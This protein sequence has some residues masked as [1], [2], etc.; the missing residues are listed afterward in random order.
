[1]PRRTEPP[2]PF[3]GDPPATVPV[4]P[5]P[6]DHAARTV[7]VDP[8]RNVALEASAGTGKTRVLVDRYV[9]L[10]EAGVDPTNVL[11]ITFTRKAAAEMRQRIVQTLRDAASRGEI[12]PARWREL[13]DR[14]GEIAISTI[15]AFCLSLLREFP[16]EADVDPGLAMADE[17]E[18]PRLIDEALDRALG[19]CRRL[20]REDEDVAL[21]FAQL[22]EARL[23]RG[24]AALL[25]RRLV[26][27]DALR[28]YL[29]R[30]PRALDAAA[31]CQRFAERL[32]AAFDGAPG[33]LD[34]FLA[35]APAEGRRFALLTREIGDLRHRVRDSLPPE[36]ARVQALIGRL[37]EVLLTQAGDP[38]RRP[39]FPKRDFASPAAYQ[40]HLAAVQVLGPLF[41]EAYQAFRR[42]LNVVVSRG[43]WR[44]FQ[45]ALGEYRETLD[46]H[47]VLDFSDVLGRALA[48]LRQMDEFSQSRYRLESRYHHVLV[49]EFQD[50]SRAQWELVSLLVQSWGEGFGLASGPLPPSIFIV[51]DRKQ[52][53]YAFRDADSA[54]LDEASRYIDALRPDG[55]VR[56]QIVQ[57]FRSVPAI[58]A[59][60][61]DVFGAVDKQPERRDG[62]RYDDRDRFPLDDGVAPE[63]AGALG[64]VAGADP[65]A[66]AEAVADEIAR[67]LE[68]GVVRDRQTGIAR[69]ARPG[70]VAILFRSRDSHREFEQALERRGIPGYVYK[71]LGFFDADEVKDVVSLLWYLADPASDLRAA[72][73]LRSRFVRLSDEA[74][75]Q[76]APRLADALE[77]HDE[78]AAMATLDDIDRAALRVAR[79]ATARWRRLIDRVPPAELLDRVLD[80]SAYA[81]ETRGPR[82]AQARENLKKIR[83]LVRRVQNRGYVTMG[84]IADHLD[85]LSAGDESNAIIDAVDAVNLMTVHASKGLEFPVVF[86]V[87]L[88]R[89]TGGGRDAIRVVADA[90]RGDDGEPKP[91]VAIGDYQSEADEDAEARE[92]EET[93]RLLYVALTR[94][95]DRLYLASVL[96]KGTWRPSRGSLGAILPASFAP[97]FSGALA[98]ADG[99]VLTW[100]TETTAHRFRVCRAAAAPRRPARA[101]LAEG[102]RPPDDFE[103]VA[104]GPHTARLSIVEAL[105]ATRPDPAR[106]GSADDEAQLAGTLVH[107]LFQH[108]PADLDSA[109]APT[110]AAALLTDIERSAIDDLAVVARAVGTWDRMRRQ[111]EVG[112]LLASGALFHEVPFS[113]RVAAPAAATPGEDVVL[114][115]TIDC[116]VRQ[117]DGRLVI[118]EFKTGAPR[119]EHTDQLAV[120]RQAVE[121]LF[122]DATIEG[123]L[124]YPR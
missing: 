14:L 87:N 2:L 80:E 17:T 57:S 19:T 89:G 71:G 76:L 69:A 110:L 36:P 107:R 101:S 4:T 124:I 100:T 49:D 51:G 48:L 60:V 18:V 122:P 120:Y 112:E 53:I 37:R 33:G 52:S 56:R 54:M 15:D 91:S 73:L 1:M 74:L 10:L 66:S 123:R 75:R 85:Q 108:A 62:F 44:A 5:D 30:G 88:A 63:R 34:G 118:L 92:R 97:L 7:A 22:G 24:L 94:A 67:V 113:L 6:P 82:A 70:D 79:E 3:D 86:L 35:A 106:H 39:A 65:A 116:L 84:R 114:R 83:G 59:F 9:N 109:A 117:P 99:E 90:G 28:R 42:D 38:R 23:R 121:A 16:L 58:L 43:V 98:A 47:A 104:A 8:T 95:R 29:A 50:T 20:A 45:I 77:R 55:D 81:I 72:A 26:A 61:N 13:S 40:R 21:V 32:M 25:D 102:P 115:G 27:P 78:P 31:A 119:P 12:P 103:P 11:A 96:P 68:D 64:V 105:A 41:A 93:K 111:P 46:A